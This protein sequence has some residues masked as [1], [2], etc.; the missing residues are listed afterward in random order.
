[1]AK[2]F[3]S[4]SALFEPSYYKGLF[5][6]VK[7]RKDKAASKAAKAAGKT[8]SAAKPGKSALVPAAKHEAGE[9]RAH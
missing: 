6:G 2:H 4:E 1:M 8:K 7:E 9:K 3:W 5:P